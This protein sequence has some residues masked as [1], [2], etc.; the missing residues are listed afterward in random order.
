MHS[1][2]LLDRASCFKVLAYY[3]LSQ[4]GLNPWAVS[5]NRPLCLE[6]AF[7]RQYSHSKRKRKDGRRYL[8]SDELLFSGFISSCMSACPNVHAHAHSYA[9]LWT[10]WV[11]KFVFWKVQYAEDLAEGKL[12]YVLKA[13]SFAMRESLWLERLI[14]HLQNMIYNH[15]HM[16]GHISP[17]PHQ[18]RDRERQQ[19]RHLFITNVLRKD[20]ERYKEGLPRSV[21][22]SR[23]CPSVSHVHTKELLFLVCKSYQKTTAKAPSAEGWRRGRLPISSLRI[24]F[25]LH[26]WVG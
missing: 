4:D 18:D 17:P 2:L 8:G 10:I 19:E 20:K 26:Q 13:S 12:S 9:L 15:V 5:P 23:A 1:S 22:E 16:C 21:A 6:V 24:S 14:F 11:E 3:L 25:P 7:I